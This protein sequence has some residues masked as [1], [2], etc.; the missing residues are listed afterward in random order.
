MKQYLAKVL[1]IV[2]GL[3]AW[4]GSKHSAIN[5]INLEFNNLKNSLSS[6]KAIQVEGSKS[7]TAGTLKKYDVVYVELITGAHFVL[8]YKIIEDKV[9]GLNITSNNRAFCIHEIK[10][11]R[12]FEGSFLTS[13]LMEIPL[14]DAKKKFVR[15]FE[16]KREA[17]LIFSTYRKKMKD[18]L[19]F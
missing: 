14:E 3:P 11:D 1:N 12:F 2:K 15:V 4:Q 13:T 8:V 16:S 7:V 19:K 18:L 10:H 5:K 17:D 6:S 9:F